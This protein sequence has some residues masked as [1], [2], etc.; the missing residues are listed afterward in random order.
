MDGENKFSSSRPSQRVGAKRR[1]MTGS[2]R[3]GTHNHRCA[4]L[5][6]RGPPSYL[7][8]KVSGYGS[9]LSPGRRK[10]ISLSRGRG[11]L[12]PLPTH[13]ANASIKVDQNRKQKIRRKL[14]DEIL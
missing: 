8:R 4:Y 14:G 1:P 11:S 13:R 7:A 6:K 10:S 3:A 5:E 12:L 9:R 2:A